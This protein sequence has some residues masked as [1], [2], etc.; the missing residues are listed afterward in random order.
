M[1]EN[2]KQIRK[3][4]AELFA[5]YRAEWLKE[6]VF[7]L[8]QEPSYFPQLTT[9]HPCFLIGGRGSGKTTVLRCLSYEGRFSMSGEDRQAVSDWEY[10]GLYYRVNTNRVAAFEGPELEPTTWTRLFGHYLNLEFSS[11]IFRHLD[12]YRRRLPDTVGLSEE[13][14]EPFYATLLLQPSGDERQAAK[15]LDIARLRFEG[16][17]NTIGD[18]AELP[19][20]SMQG[21]PVDALMTAVRALPQYADLQFFFLID[22]YENFSDY[23]QRICNT[24]IK[25]C[26]ELYSFKVGVRELGLRQ[27]STLNEHEKLVH[28]ADYKR[29]DISD[30]LEGR[31]GDFAAQVCRQRLAAALGPGAEI[32]EIA[33]MFPAVSAEEE[34]ELLGVEG[35]VTATRRALEEDTSLPSN[36]AAWTAELS[37]LE[38]FSLNCRAKAE[39]LT[40][41]EKVVNAVEDLDRWKGHYNNYKHAYLFAIRKGKRGIRKYYAGWDTYTLVAGNNIRFILELVDQALTRHL[42][43]APDTFGGI[44]PQI[45]THAAQATGEKNLR[46]IEGISVQHGA[47]LAR[48]I[49][50]L[51]RVFQVM[52]ENPVGHAPEVNQFTVSPPADVASNLQDQLDGILTAA[53]MHLALVRYP[54][55][56]LQDP[57]DIKDYDF[58]VH[59]IYAPYFGFSHRKKRKLVLLAEDIIRLVEDT[60][61]AVHTILE[62]QNR[63]LDLQLPEQMRLFEGF[64]ASST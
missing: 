55:S 21:A 23:Q 45:Q 1:R 59:P 42:D 6:E 60:P 25:H 30:E 33:D 12:W 13:A 53:V 56:K 2:K 62:R 51:G 27:K 41:S 15:A 10:V 52:A 22:E 61:T 50:G 11:L 18:A 5:G 38:V 44:S 36:A 46:E 37:G 26:G 49:L 16:L 35:A 28:P 31:F 47:K 14:L 48:L 29:I 43:S 17:I 24:L 32:P 39:G 54:G 19:P 57:S 40:V 9:S 7:R 20:L 58:A 3:A 4:L 8:F 64:Y 34:A 63:P